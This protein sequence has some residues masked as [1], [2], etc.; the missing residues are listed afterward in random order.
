MRTF[1]KK[2]IL[3]I[4]LFFVLDFFIYT[5]LNLLFKKSYLYWPQIIKEQRITLLF[6]GDS[7]IHH[8]IIPEIITKG[9]G[10]PT[11]NLAGYGYGIIFAQGAECLLPPSDKPRIIVIGIT[12]LLND[13]AAINNLAPY[14]MLPAVRDILNTYP[15]GTRLRYSLCLSA[16]FNAKILPLLFSLGKKNIFSQ[17]GYAPLYGKRT[18]RYKFAIETKRNKFASLEQG[19]NILMHSLEKAQHSGIKVIFVD[20]PTKDGR[21][22][23][24]YSVYKEA[25]ARYAI[26]YLDFSRAR[27]DSPQFTDECFWDNTHLNDTGAHLFSALLAEQ[28]KGLL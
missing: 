27:T 5:G 21:K 28:L 1:I 15:I 20:M 3:A 18:A 4:L 2:S 16:R 11:L 6:I 19:K 25:A 23:K 26:P 7:K 13:N 14:F 17:D 22:S 24:N 9:T 8:G 12:Q 10:M